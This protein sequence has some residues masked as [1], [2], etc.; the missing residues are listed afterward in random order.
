MCTGNVSDLELH[1]NSNPTTL[2]RQNLQKNLSQPCLVS[3]SLQQLAQANQK[4]RGNKATVS[5]SKHL[6]D[7]QKSNNKEIERKITVAKMQSAK[8]RQDVKEQETN[9]IRL[10]DEVSISSCNETV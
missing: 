10:Q 3:L 9:F 7:L 1:A 6:L 2:N 5:E 4:I 8:L